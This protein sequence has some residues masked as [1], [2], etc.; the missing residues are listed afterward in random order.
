[1]IEKDL[2]YS[3]FYGLYAFVA[4]FAIIQSLQIEMKFSNTELKRKARIISGFFIIFFILLIGLRAYDVG[5]DT[6][7]YFRAWNRKTDFEFST[8]YLYYLIMVGVKNIGFSYQAFLLIVS[9][10]FFYPIYRV[11]K[12]ISI[13][14]KADFLLSLFA[15]A[16]FFFFMST[17]INVARQGLSLVCLL[18][19]YGVFIQK[20]KKN[21]TTI[22]ILCFAAISFHLTAIIPIILFGL[23]YF[24][25][26]IPLIYFVIVFVIAMLL[27]Y[28][29]F[30]IKNFSPY[31][32]D[33]L[34]GD[35]RVSYLGTKELD[36]YQVGFRPQFAAFNTIFLII[37]LYINHYIRIKP[38]NRLL[39]YY[40]LASSLFF[41]AFQLNFSDRWGLF[42]W[43]VIPLLLIP[44]YQ[45]NSKLNIKP[46]FFTLF[47]IFVFIF[48]NLL[49]D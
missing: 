4:F 40:I 46:S 45:Y 41:M 44:I 43:F 6:L 8:D 28:V 36:Y 24:T 38:Y 10:L 31:L 47:L 39:K 42:S 26:R 27:S 19:A 35:K 22:L 9:V 34:E 18:I 14:Y 25:Q 1:M 5:A 13:L 21:L 20:N 3:I 49:Y 29:N 12:K 15:F 17:S 23:T 48:F 2:F 16:S 7:S 32:V 37:F 30:G 33:I 11:Y